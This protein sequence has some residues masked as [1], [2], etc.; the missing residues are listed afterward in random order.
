M[1]YNHRYLTIRRYWQRIRTLYYMLA[2]KAF[3]KP[4]YPFYVNLVINSRCNLKCA[5]CFGLYSSRKTPDWAYEDLVKLID[6]LHARGTRYILVQGGEP[7]L[8]PDLGKIFRYIDS[9]G[10]VTAL[11]TNGQFPERIREIP[12]I[13]LLDNICF[14]LDGNREGNDRIRGKGTFDKVLESIQ[15][16]KEVHRTPIRLNTTITKY[17]VHDVD[18]M[19]EFV[20]D[21]NIE[22][23]INFLFKGDERLGEE[24]L[25]PE[26]EDIIK[27][28]N[29]FVDYIRRGYPI[30]S[31]TKILRYTLNWPVPY[32]R[33][34]LGR[35]E[36][37]RLMGK[38][39]IEC[40]YGNYEIVIDEDG[41]LYPCQGMQGMFDGKN[42]K[43]VGFDEAFKHLETKPCYTCYLVSMINTSAM[44]NWDM[45]V[46][47][48]TIRGTFRSRLWK[49]K[50]AS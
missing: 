14:S 26:D 36:S 46:I 12:E 23:G 8:H 50:K 21:N 44:I 29:K 5:Y 9:K 20:R 38:K 13:A 3:N 42:L 30:F 24:D 6:D 35:E 41:R 37:L 11:V 33:K 17:T 16:V 48:E 34:F 1:K 7:L 32:T 31:T 39:A 2:I 15:V 18:F 43:E 4:R 40:Q 10:I 49:S 22:W 19:A 27:Y 47:G 28:Q 25:A 45:N